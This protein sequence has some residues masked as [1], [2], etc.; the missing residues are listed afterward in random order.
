MP[1]N[2]PSCSV[3]VPDLEGG[4]TLYK[5]KMHVKM[6]K[7]FTA[8]ANRR[9]TTLDSLRFLLDGQH[10]YEDQMPSLLNLDRSSKIDCVPAQGVSAA[11][12]LADLNGNIWT[13]CLAQEDVVFENTRPLAWK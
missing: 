2:V 11:P 4:E 12:W 5:I 7:I 6:G 8:H 1:I 9:S 3:T 13:S 10:V